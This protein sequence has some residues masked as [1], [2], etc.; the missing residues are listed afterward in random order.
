MG[1]IIKQLKPAAAVQEDLYV[2]PA[3]LLFSS[4][5]SIWVVNQSGSNSTFRVTVA[6]LGVPDAPEQDLFTDNQICPNET[7]RFS[8]DETFQTGDTI[9]VSSNS[10]NV[11]FNYFGLETASSST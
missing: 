8:L 4:A 2:V 6:P 10:G 1:R 5:R 9:R 3:G 11:S 7:L